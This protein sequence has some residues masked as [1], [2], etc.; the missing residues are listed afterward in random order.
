M[1][2]L[3]DTLPPTSPVKIEQMEKMSG[4]WH[5]EVRDPN[6]PKSTPTGTLANAGASAAYSQSFE[7]HGPSLGPRQPTITSP[8]RSTTFAA[9]TD[10]DRVDTPLSV[11]KSCGSTIKSLHKTKKD[12]RPIDTMDRFNEER[13]PRP[14]R[15]PPLSL[16]HIAKKGFALANPL[17]AYIPSWEMD[18][19]RWNTETHEKFQDPVKVKFHMIMNNTWR[20]D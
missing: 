4:T 9:G 5:S 18:R 17:T 12:A 16:R 7:H 15:H 1:T 20:Y 11:C 8:I 3:V 19:A 6:R 10:F 14:W 13:W 2:D